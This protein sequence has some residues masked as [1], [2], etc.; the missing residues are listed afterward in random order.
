MSRIR[1]LVI[2]LT[3]LGG[4][5]AAYLA[6]RDGPRQTPPA[7]LV[8]R[9][10]RLVT[11]DDRVPEAQALAARDGRIVAVG[12]DAEIAEH[13]GPSTQVID[14]NGQFAMPGFIEGHGHFTG[15]G[16]YQ[17]NL[18]LLDATS[19]DQIVQSVAQAVEKAKPGEWISGR[20]W[21]QEKWTVPPR[22]SVE[23][24]PTHESLDAVSPNNPVVLRHA[25]GHASFVNRKAMELSNI[26]RTT[27]NPAGGEILKDASG[28]PTGL[29]RETAAGLVREGAGAPVP[30]AE[31]A[32]VRARQLLE[33]ADQEV[34]SKGITS[35]QDAGA[36]YEVIDRMKRLIDAGAL[37][38]RLWVMVR[39]NDTAALAAGLDR[40]RLVGYG[41]DRLT[42]RAM[43]ASIDGALGSRGAWLLEPYAD[44]PDSSGLGRSIDS[45][46]E[47]ARL[48]IE[49]GYQLCTHAIGDRANRE[50]LNIYEETFKQYGKDGTELRW[51][52]EHA[53][54]L[55]ASDIPRFGQIGVVASMQTV[56][57]TSDAV[58]V[59][60]RLGGAR[61]AEGAYVWQKLMQA[62]AIVTNGTDAP[63]ED[64]DPLPNY[65][66]AV[67][68]KV[69]DGSVFYAGQTMTRLEALRAYTINNAFAAFEDDIKGTL[70][71]GKLA[72]ITVLT[73]DITRVPDEE[74][75]QTK[76]AYTIIGGTVAYQGR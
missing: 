65:Y 34:I 68:R 74:I 53:Q 11:L 22:T 29:L 46:R 48:A 16:E 7:D 67:T 39:E 17:S 41:G 59:P 50:V 9:G 8:L 61:A 6:L 51:R 27:P 21:H 30:T 24:F 25:S 3:V 42:V 20:G 31:E 10:G 44:Q 76:V 45:I 70:S 47:T 40:A 63:V 62:G 35:F 75:T 57:A 14:L 18:E 15:I 26:T 13:I 37:H 55:S 12:S 64:V 23:G 58:F 49:H 56:H 72:D 32:E 36:P 71:I 54:H 69:S 28:N 1:I 5:G 66:A 2:A 43:K 60:A 73:R 33:L 52:I 38:V 4:T 19:W